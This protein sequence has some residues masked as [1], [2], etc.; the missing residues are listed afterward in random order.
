MKRFIIDIGGPIG[1][2]P[3][4]PPTPPRKRVSHTYRW[5]QLRLHPA[6]PQE[7][8]A[9]ASASKLLWTLGDCRE[10]D[11][12]VPRE[13]SETTDHDRPLLG[14]LFLCLSGS[15]A[16]RRVEG[17]LGGETKYA[18]RESPFRPDNVFD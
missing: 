8:G 2:T 1:E 14:F 5:D 15:E 7:C 6:P 17:N 4:G 11:K 3:E 12:L 9:E 13:G 10:K 18:I 16:V